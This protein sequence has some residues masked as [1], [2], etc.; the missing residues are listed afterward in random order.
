MADSRRQRILAASI[1]VLEG[2]TI[3]NGYQTNLG[4]AVLFGEVPAFGDGDPKQVLA[5]FP[6]EDQPGDLQ[7][8]KVLI[9]LP[10]DVAIILAPGVTNAGAVREAGI[11]D[12]KKA[13]EADRSL[14]GLLS[15]GRNHPE[16]MIRGTTETFDRSTGSEYVG[17][18]ISW[19]LQYYESLGLPEA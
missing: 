15:G 14:G 1:A 8:G 7:V 10:V 5:L 11:A 9:V 12:V 18:I 3:A 4:D 13:M 17:A 2:I 6:R 19:G 16:G